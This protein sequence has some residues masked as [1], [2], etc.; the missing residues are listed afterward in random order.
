M[1]RNEILRWFLIAALTVLVAAGCAKKPA[2]STGV[3]PPAGPTVSEAPVPTERPGQEDVRGIEERPV[4]E[5]EAQDALLPKAD[6]TSAGLERIFFQFDQY[7]LTDEARETLNRNASFLKANPK[8]KVR[9]E[10]H[11]DERGSDEYNLALGER[12][13][14]SAR[15]YVV[16]LGI[17]GSRLTTTSYGEEMPLETGGDESAWSK[18]RRAEFNVIGR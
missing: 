11:S 8:L 1:K 10:G 17:D 15:D 6:A 3:T 9:V 4:T 12:R 13:A 2:P 7:T 16:S 5:G 18:N 14:R